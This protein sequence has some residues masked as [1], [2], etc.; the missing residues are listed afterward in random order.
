M[1]INVNLEKS[2]TKVEGL[3][4][5]LP[6][7]VSIDKNRIVITDSGNNRICVL[8]GDREYSIGGEFGLGKYKFKEPVYSTSV[9][10]LIFSCDWH[11]H[12]VVVYKDKVFEQQIGLYGILNKSKF[13]NTL[14]LLRNFKS[15]GSFNYSH[16]NDDKNKRS[17]SLLTYCK[18]I[19]ESITFYLINPSIF[20]K[21]ILNETYINKPNGCV[22]INDILY[23]TQKDNHCVTAYDLSSNKIIMQIDNSSE[24]IAFGR[25]GQIEEFNEK[26]Y[27]CDET[28]NKVWILNLN[29]ELLES[30]SITNYSIFSISINSQYIVTCGTT[31]FSLFDHKYNLLF[32]KN[33]DGEY[34][35]VCIDSNYFYIVNRLNHRIEKYEIKG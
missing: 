30:V 12:R 25:L 9:G 11:N 27:V 20:L 24:N 29:L 28:N 22:C 19:A 35:G 13:L 17:T 21:N 34:H 23:F 26:L 4:L 5:L 10:D 14:R 8:D 32:E 15:N 1:C 2:Y 18:N 6:N 31:S 7:S 3:D 33:G 16:F